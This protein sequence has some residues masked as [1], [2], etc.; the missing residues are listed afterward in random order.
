MNFLNL[1]HHLKNLPYHHMRMLT[2]DNLW[3]VFS[4]NELLHHQ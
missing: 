4:H 2:K 3:V 1:A